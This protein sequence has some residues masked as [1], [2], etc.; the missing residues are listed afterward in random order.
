MSQCPKITLYICTKQINF[1]RNSSEGHFR[2]PSLSWYSSSDPQ[3]TRLARLCIDSILLICFTKY[4]FQTWPWFYPALLCVRNRSIFPEK[5]PAHS[6]HAYFITDRTF[7]WIAKL[8]INI[9]NLL[10]RYS[11]VIYYLPSTPDNH[12]YIP[13]ESQSFDTWVC[14]VITGNYWVQRLAKPFFPRRLY[15]YPIYLLKYDPVNI[16]ISTSYR[17]C[18][19]METACRMRFRQ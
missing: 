9:S 6:N 15:G 18:A 19:N 17:L 8:R 16:V 1:L 12:A 4:G 2:T 11:H 7:H 10:R 5:P 14:C 13:E 3:M